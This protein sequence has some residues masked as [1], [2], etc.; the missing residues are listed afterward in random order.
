MRDFNLSICRD[1]QPR[2]VVSRTIFEQGRRSPTFSF[3]NLPP[4]FDGTRKMRAKSV[5]LE[6]YIGEGLHEGQSDGVSPNLETCKWRQMLATWI[7]IKRKPGFDKFYR[8]FLWINRFSSFGRFYI[9]RPYWNTDI[10]NPGINS[11][12][13][14]GLY[15][16]KIT[17]SMHA[18][19]R[20][21]RK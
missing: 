20:A 4:E 3:R 10:Q 18:L 5:K 11:Q 16:V 15:A 8:I 12:G 7:V 17:I 9:I 21:G 13:Q 6:D 19:Y 2:R 1:A 14:K